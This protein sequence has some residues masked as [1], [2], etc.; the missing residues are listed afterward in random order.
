MVNGL[1]L[2]GYLLVKGVWLR[3]RRMYGLLTVG[4][5]LHDV[6][7]GRMDVISLNKIF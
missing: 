4:L 6:D 7:Q 2:L 1:L 3:Y 5:A